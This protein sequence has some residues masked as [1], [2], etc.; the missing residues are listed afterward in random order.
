VKRWGFSFVA[1]LIVASFHS[2]AQ[3]RTWHVK[4]N[5]S[6]D[7]PTIQA[8]TD[9]ANFGD[10]V[11]VG[12]G[13][14]SWSNQSTGNDYGLI[15]ILRG[16]ADM[17]IVSET[18]AATTILDAQDQGR[19]FFFQGPTKLTIDGFTFARGNASLTGD[20]IGAAFTAH[21][22]SPILKHCVFRDNYAERGGAIW[23]GG[24][25]APQFIDCIFERNTALRGGAVF[26]INSSLTTT[27]QDCIVR[28]NT[29]D[30]GAG[31]FAYHVVV[32]IEDTIFMDNVSTTNSGGIVAVNKLYPSEITRTTFFRNDAGGGPAIDVSG[33]SDLTVTNTIVAGTDGTGGEITEP[34]TLTFA[35]SNIVGST[36]GDWTGSIAAQ[37]NVNGN[38]SA[39]P[40]F[41]ATSG[42]LLLQLQADSPCAPGNNPGGDVSCGLIG[43]RPVGCGSVPVLE[44]SWGA[45]KALYQ[46]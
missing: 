12:P 3:A 8:A 19:I 18:G 16:A 26:L 33:A 46:D 2:S 34:S 38:F 22:S 32:R 42:S 1:L 39:P 6:G 24:V 40:L 43:A 36:G 44:R 28:N 7:A 20:Y 29:A 23:Y 17:T 4:V 37:N 9:S 31:V 35:C 14:Y 13:T 10:T 27:M 5:G 45:I 15:H 11:L 25:G 30:E 41:C 21:L